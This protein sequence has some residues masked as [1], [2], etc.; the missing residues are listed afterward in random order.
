MIEPP[1]WTEIVSFILTSEWLPIL[2]HICL[3]LPQLKNIQSCISWN[4][5]G[6]KG[7]HVDTYPIKAHS[8]KVFYFSGVF[9]TRNWCSSIHMC[10]KSSCLFK[11]FWI[12][13]VLYKRK[14][15]ENGKLSQLSNPTE[16]YDD[17]AG[18]IL[19]FS[20]SNIFNTFNPISH[21]SHSSFWNNTWRWALHVAKASASISLNVFAFMLSDT[22]QVCVQSDTAQLHWPGRST[23]AI[24]STATKRFY[25]AKHELLLC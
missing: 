17:T 13:F 18:S 9:W 15:G 25:S 19:Y 12:L 5:L 1:N 22:L 20:L 2:P 14:R 23:A 6:Q 24:F 21:W 16:E 7:P 3:P 8:T 10:P 11:H 4:S